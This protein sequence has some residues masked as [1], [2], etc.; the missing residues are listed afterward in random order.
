M[1]GLAAMT[2]AFAP[3]TAHAV[4]A[5]TFSLTSSSCQVVVGPTNAV[6][7]PSVFEI[8][9]SCAT[10]ASTNVNPAGAGTPTLGTATVVIHVVNSTGPNDCNSAEFNVD[11]SVD[12]ADPFGTIMFTEPPAMLSAMPWGLDA[13]GIACSTDYPAYAT[14]HGTIN[15]VG[16][17]SYLTVDEVCHFQAEAPFGALAEDVLAG[18]LDLSADNQRS[19]SACSAAN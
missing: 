9:I 5:V 11:I 19:V 1:A 4:K 8:V 6:P 12:Y 3:L 16:T 18:D 13:S 2:A 10:T 7:P 15:P 17:L 14:G